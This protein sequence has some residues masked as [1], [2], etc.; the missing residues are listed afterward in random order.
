MTLRSPLPSVFHRFDRVCQR[1]CQRPCQR[2]TS[3]IRSTFFDPPTPLGAIEALAAASVAASATVALKGRA[4]EE[5][6]G[7]YHRPHTANAEPTSDQA[8]IMRG[9]GRATNRLTWLRSPRSALPMCFPPLRRVLQFVSKAMISFG[10]QHRR[11]ICPNH[12]TSSG[13]GVSRAGANSVFHSVEADQAGARRSTVGETAEL[14]EMHGIDGA[15]FR[16]RRGWGE[17]PEPSLAS[18]FHGSFAPLSKNLG[19]RSPR[20]STAGAR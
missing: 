13:E 20:P 2:V 14:A 17:N 4:G 15:P 19:L 5:R 3:P 8:S 1:P 16:D 9:R 12:V 11:P 7:P 10:N 6:K 18:T